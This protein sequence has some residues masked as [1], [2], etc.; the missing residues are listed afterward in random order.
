M[1]DERRRIP[2][3]ASPFAAGAPRKGGDTIMAAAL[4]GIFDADIRVIAHFLCRQP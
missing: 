2:G 3:S 4:Y 1:K